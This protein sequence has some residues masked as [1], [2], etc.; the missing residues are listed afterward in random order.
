MAETTAYKQSRNLN[1]GRIVIFRGSPRNPGEPIGERPAIVT[2]VHNAEV[3]DLFVFFMVSPPAPVVGCYYS[4][5]PLANTWCWCD[6]QD[7]ETQ[8]L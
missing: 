1:K 3:V 6:E 5:E 4:R 7:M 2:R 8:A